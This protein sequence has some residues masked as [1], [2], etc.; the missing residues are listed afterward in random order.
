MEMLEIDQKEVIMKDTTAK[1]I[2]IIGVLFFIFGFV[3]WLNSVLIP[4]LKLACRLNNFESLLVAFAFYISYFVMAIPS[5][6]ILKYSGFKK[7]MSLGLFIMA[8][9]AVIF[10]PAATTRMYPLF[11]LGLFIQGTGLTLLQAASNPYITVLGPPE[12]AAKRISIMGICNKVA[13]A[14]APVALGLIALKGVDALKATLPTLSAAEQ[15]VALN[16]L[17][18]RVIGPYIAMAIVLTLLAVFIY[19]SALPEID[20]EHEDEKLAQANSS[21]T[22]ILQFPHLLLGLLTM[23]LYVGVEVLAGDTII[24]YGVTQGIALSTARFFSTLTL[25][26]M[27]MGYIAGIVC[28]PKLISQ[29]IALKISALL[30]ALFAIIAVITNGFTSVLFIALMG[31]ANSLMW[32]ALWPLALAGLGR[33]TKIGSSLLIMG[34][35]GGAILPLAYGALA[36]AANTRVAYLIMVPAYLFIWFY[37]VRG[38]KITYGRV[39]AKK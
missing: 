20:T 6:K 4:Y 21:K 17:S 1:P 12:S 16:E 30:G 19:F 24:N 38:H 14:I 3:T 34:I 18:S 26:C 11:L 32:P 28:I 36:D 29:E 13:G 27:I 23:F 22:S 7:G 39:N 37:G 31:L 25:S 10:I 5:A 35:A 9:G 33:F 2:I 8:C 15:E